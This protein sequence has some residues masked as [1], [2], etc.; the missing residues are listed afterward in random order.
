MRNVS[1]CLFGSSTAGILGCQSAEIHSKAIKASGAMIQNISAV[2]G[3][4]KTA[5]SEKSLAGKSG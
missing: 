4:A 2:C 1:S 5:A 3:F